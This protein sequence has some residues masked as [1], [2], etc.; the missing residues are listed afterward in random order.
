M[1]YNAMITR[2]MPCCG[3]TAE[4]G[5]V[6]HIWRGYKSHEGIPLEC[7]I[8]GRTHIT[9]DVSHT[10]FG[11]PI[12]TSRLTTLPVVNF[13]GGIETE[14][15]RDKKVDPKLRLV[16]AQYLRQKEEAMRDFKRRNGR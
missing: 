1:G 14:D 3:S 7:H 2:P 12:P 16:M 8:C 15:K 13:P 11:H 10:L 9:N 6:V 5:K 4:I